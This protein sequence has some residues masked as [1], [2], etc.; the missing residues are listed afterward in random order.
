MIDDSTV[1]KQGNLYLPDYDMTNHWKIRKVTPSA[2]VSTMP[3]QDNTGFPS[4]LPANTTVWYDAAIACDST[5]NL[6]VT[7]NGNSLIKKIDPQGVATLLAGTTIGFKDGKGKD[8]L[9]YNILGIAV[10]VS[11]NLFVCDGGNH[12]IRKITPD[13]TVT[14]IAGNG[15]PGFANGDSTTARFKYPNRITID[16]NGAL[17]VS[18]LGNSAVRK[19]VY[20]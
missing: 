13:G 10:D 18:E 8:A 4:D 9:F 2:L 1:D 6:Y 3:L 15:T 12:A 7:G 17:Y 5:G 16:K 11:G 14:T 19:L 20:Q